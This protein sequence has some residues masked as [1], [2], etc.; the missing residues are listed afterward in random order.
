MLFV[1]GS[2]FAMVGDSQYTRIERGK[3][4]VRA[5]DCAAC[6]TDN[7]GKPFAGGLAV[8]TPF[9]KIYSTNITPDKETGIG[10]WSNE[11]FWRAMHFGVRHDGEHLYPAMPYPSYTKLTREDV[12]A[13]KTYL[14]TI[15]PVHNETKP[16]ELPWPL[17]WRG[18]MAVW[19]EMFFTPGTYKSDPHKSEQWNRGAYLVQGAGHCGACHTPRNFAGAKQS[20][21][22]LAGGDAGEHWYA[23][24]LTKGLREGLGNWSAQDIVTYLKTG[25]TKNTAAAGPMAEVVENSTK[26]LTE[27]DL[28]AIAVYLKDLPASDQDAS[29]T[30]DRNRKNID[31]RRMLTGAALYQDNCAA[32]HMENGQGLPNVFPSLKGSSLVQAKKPDAVMH[33]VLKGGKRPDTPQRPAQFAMPSFDSKLND[34][35]IADLVTYVRN[36]WGNSAAAVD[37]D[38]V[39]TIRKD[40]SK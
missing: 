1:F 23:P 31:S 5:G 10:K 15:E 30:S 17:S 35:Q 36:A 20:D 22:R 37:G 2:V 40:L 7:G 34:A 8:P 19:N 32:C 12:D 6:H 25:A 4:L 18:G 9:G 3:Y 39:K 29:R 27:A 11:D 26:Y 13:I 14:D 38:L 28:N 24:E 33:L 16:P 21:D